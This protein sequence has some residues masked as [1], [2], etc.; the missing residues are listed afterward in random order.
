MI[1]PSSDR[2][3]YDGSGQ[4]EDLVEGGQLD[5]LFLPGQSEAV[6]E[7]PAGKAAIEL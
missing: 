2:P 6:T 7:P 3:E 5:K 4:P 1:H